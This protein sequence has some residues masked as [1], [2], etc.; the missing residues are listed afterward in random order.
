MSYGIKFVNQSGIVTFDPAVDSPMTYVGTYTVP[1]YSAPGSSFVTVPGLKNDNHWFIVTSNS[2]SLYTSFT[3]TNDTFTSS[4]ASPAT[5]MISSISIDVYRNDNTVTPSSGYG[6]WMKND[7]G[8]VSAQTDYTSWLVYS[9]PTTVISGTTLPTL[10]SN[11]YYA[12]RPISSSGYLNF[13]GS[14]SSPI[15]SSSV[16]SDIEYISVGPATSLPISSSGY[17]LQIFNS[18][19]NLMFNGSYRQVISVSLQN[20]LSSSTIS[21]SFGSKTPYLLLSETG[22]RRNGIQQISGTSGVF[23]ATVPE[24]TSA[25]SGNSVLIARSGGAPPANSGPFGT[26]LHTFFQISG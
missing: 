7:L 3:V 13:S 24:W 23:T 2:P 11:F 10:P 26:S 25:T 22:F 1:T 19:G 9:G 17:G 15:V 4:T 6:F 21:W 5:G 12:A 18:S 14:V 16:Y 20:F 8:Y